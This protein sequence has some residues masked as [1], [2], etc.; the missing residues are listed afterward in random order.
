MEK[1]KKSNFWE[2]FAPKRGKRARFFFIDF[3][4]RLWKNLRIKTDQPDN[5][6]QIF[7]KSR[8]SDH[9]EASSHLR[10]LNVDASVLPHLSRIYKLCVLIIISGAI[11]M[12][13]CFRK[14]GFQNFC[15]MKNISG[16]IYAPVSNVLQCVILHNEQKGDERGLLKLTS[17]TLITYYK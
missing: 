5:K 16:A 12:P 14:A 8:V 11:W 7:T 3:Q 6:T 1:T 15:V 2:L 17:S 10:A 4:T 13:L 9:N